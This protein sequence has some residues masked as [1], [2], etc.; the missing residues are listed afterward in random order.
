MLLPHLAKLVVERF[1]AVGCGV[2]VWGRS[3]QTSARCP[4]CGRLTRRVHSRYQRRVEDIV[5]GGQQVELLLRMRIFICPHADCTVTRFAEQVDGLTHRYGRRTLPARHVLQALGLALAGRPAARL[6][7]SLGIQAGRN[8]LLRLV[9]AIPDRQFGPVTVLGVDDFALRRG[10]RYGTILID[11]NTHTP[12]DVLPDRETDTLTAWLQANPGAQVICRDRAGAYAEAARRGAPGAVQ[13]ADR[14]HLWHNLAQHVEKTVARHQRCLAPPP[15]PPTPQPT[16]DAEAVA[17]LAAVATRD[18][19]LAQR[20]RDRFE[21]V[22][23]LLNEG[24]SIKA[25]VRDL[26]LARETVRRYARATDIEDLVAAARTGARGSILD[27]Y[28]EH[29]HQRWA[30]GGTDAKALFNELRGMGYP[31]SYSVLRDYLRALRPLTTVPPAAPRPPKVRHVVNWLL[32]HPQRMEPDDQIGLAAV[33]ARCQHLD[34]LAAHVTAFA[35]I[36]TQRRGH[37][38]D[39]WINAVTDDDQPDLHSF[40]AGLQRD[41]DAVR[42]GLTLPHNSGAVEGHVNRIKMLKRQMFGRANFDLLRK[43]VLHTT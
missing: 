19:R 27:P 36:L 7:T 32:R 24:R 43:R 42:N 8:T 6:A 22:H 37:E 23:R 25:I 28:L 30:A 21:Q 34:R 15:E 31:G 5:V 20:T 26:G 41:Y 38:L 11:L 4:G 39:A 18:G 1:E 14:W 13:V 33:R 35:V 3:A 16:L 10:H 29:L 12:V 2:R 40:A 17:A 9:R